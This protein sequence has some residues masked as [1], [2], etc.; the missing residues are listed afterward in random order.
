MR[1]FIRGITLS[2]NR[3]IKYQRWSLIHRSRWNSIKK[4]LIYNNRKF[5]FW[6]RDFKRSRPSWVKGVARNQFS[7]QLSFLLIL[8][9][10]AN[11][12]MRLAWTVIFK[13]WTLN[14]KNQT[15]W[16]SNQLHRPMSSM[17]NMVPKKRNRRKICT[18]KTTIISKTERKL[19][20]KKSLRHMLIKLLGPIQNK[21]LEK[22]KS[23]VHLLIDSWNKW[24]LI[25]IDNQRCTAWESALKHLAMI[26]TVT[27]ASNLSTKAKKTS[28]K[29]WAK[30][31]KKSRHC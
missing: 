7:R 11:C 8:Q 31:R 2:I 1:Y 30:K 4:R 14:K 23:Q 3:M 28:N 16:I 29:L 18:F 13:K 22:M 20:K 6:H 10:Q 19:L 15:I 5:I 24:V 21:W 27:Q 17:K 12:I 25:Y 9:A 26:L